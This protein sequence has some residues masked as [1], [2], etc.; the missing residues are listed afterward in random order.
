MPHDSYKLRGSRPNGHRLTTNPF[1]LPVRPPSS[2]EDSRDRTSEQLHTSAMH[3]LN[4]TQNAMTP[5]EQ[6]ESLVLQAGGHIFTVPPAPTTTSADR[7]SSETVETIHRKWYDRGL[8]IQKHERRL[9]DSNNLLSKMWRRLDPY[10]RVLNLLNND[11]VV[12]RHAEQRA[13]PAYSENPHMQSLFTLLAAYDYVHT[14]DPDFVLKSS[15]ST[16]DAAATEKRINSLAAT[17]KLQSGLLQEKNETIDKLRTQVAAQRKVEKKHM[18]SLQQY[19]TQADTQYS[20]KR[21]QAQISQQVDAMQQQLVT[22]QPESQHQDKHH[23][24]HPDQQVDLQQY[25]NQPGDLQLKD[26]D[27]DDVIDRLNRLLQKANDRI[28]VLSNTPQPPP[29]PPRAPR[30]RSTH[31]TRPPALSPRTSPPATKLPETAFGG[32]PEN[33][34]S[35]TFDGFSEHNSFNP[36]RLQMLTAVNPGVRSESPMT[37]TD[38]AAPRSSGANSAPLGPLKRRYDSA[39]Q[40]SGNS[41]AHTPMASHWSSNVGPIKYSKRDDDGSRRAV[42][43][44]D[45]DDPD[46]NMGEDPQPVKRIRTRSGVLTPPPLEDLVMPSTERDGGVSIKSETVDL[47]VGELEEAST[48]KYAYEE[49][50]EMISQAQKDAMA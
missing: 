2:W 42:S 32:V 49:L 24:V 34:M 35:L 46:E 6:L 3:Q 20:H 14:I 12:R 11:A 47:E 36:A 1:S 28:S 45:Y 44:L 38:A 41:R 10:D 5:A 22:R 13:D 39:M 31:L 19:V 40:S 29:K 16:T 25:G 4:L 8:L 17:V 26:K 27:K 21:R 9:S 50:D 37:M 33:H 48:T 43:F 15:T 30:A 7:G 23:K 18:D